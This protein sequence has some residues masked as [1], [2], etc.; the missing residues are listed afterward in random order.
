M[1]PQLQCFSAQVWLDSSMYLPII[2]DEFG[3]LNG[4]SAVVG[5]VGQVPST[6]QSIPLHFEH[7]VVEKK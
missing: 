1:G 2:Q 5:Y 6:T 7:V 4:R 3:F